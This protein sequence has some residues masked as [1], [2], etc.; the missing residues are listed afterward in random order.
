MIELARIET[1]A[2]NARNAR[3]DARQ[4]HVGFPDK[5]QAV[6]LDWYRLP[7][8]HVGCVNSCQRDPQ[9]TR[10]VTVGFRNGT[11]CESL[12]ASGPPWVLAMSIPSF[13]GNVA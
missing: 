9:P 13:G 8:Q 1:K 2:V 11:H 7:V 4:L 3:R 10:D 5:S 12:W 6:R